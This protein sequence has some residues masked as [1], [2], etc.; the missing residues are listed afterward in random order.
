MAASFLAGALLIQAVSV[1]VI[2]LVDGVLGSAALCQSTRGVRV[3]VCLC[4]CVCGRGT[5]VLTSYVPG[6][7]QVNTKTLTTSGQSVTVRSFEQTISKHEAE[8]F[9]SRPLINLNTNTLAHQQMNFF[10]VFD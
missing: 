4:V 6:N 3:C 5:H 2:S 7:I 10:H 1:L 9:S 8:L